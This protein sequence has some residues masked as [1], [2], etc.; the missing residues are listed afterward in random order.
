[1]EKTEA[2]FV[3]PRKSLRVEQMVAKWLHR[4]RESSHRILV[5][6]TSANSNP[7]NFPVK[8]TV[9]I[10]KDL[11]LD[12]YGFDI[13]TYPPIT[14]IS[15]TAGGPSEGK[16]L[17][18]DQILEVN[19]NPME[20]LSSEQIAGVIR[21]SEDQ[22][23]ITILRYSP[24]PK[25]SFLTAEKRARLRSNPVKVHFAEEVVVNGHTQGNSLLFM[26]NVLKVYLENGQTKAFK[27]EKKTT[28]KDIILTLKEKLS[29]HCIEHFALALEEQ[30]HISK[31]YLLH[32][33]EL[34]EK[35]A[36]NRDVRDYRCLF[37]VCFVPKDPLSLLQDD[38]VAF[39]Y[40]YL[41]S[42]SDVIQERF[43]AEMKCS[44]ALRLAALHIQERIITCAQ[45]QKISLKYIEKDWGIENFISPTLLRNMKGKDIK[46]AISFHMK[47]NQSLLEPRQKQLIS[48]AQARLN[49]LKILGDLK[50]YG[51]KIFNATILLQDRESC[52]TLLV[53]AKYGV[54]QVI[55]NKLN[56]MTTLAD[57]GNIS[58]IELSPESEKVS[59]VKI[60]LQDVKPITLLMESYNAKDLACLIAGYCRLF[61]DSSVSFFTWHEKL[62][63]RLSVE[64]GY[65]SRGCSDSEESSEIDSSLELF[66]DLHLLKK[67]PIKTL[68]EEDEGQETTESSAKDKEPFVCDSTDNTSDNSLSA[69]DS[70][71]TESR[72][73]KLS[74]S[75]D[76]L[77]A[78]EDDDLATCSASMPEFFQLYTSDLKET[79]RKDESIFSASTDKG[80]STEGKYTAE[81]DSF[82]SFLELPQL[83]DSLND[84]QTGLSNGRG[85]A[86]QAEGSAANTFSL[87][88]Q[89]YNSGTMQYYSLCSNVTPDGNMES[90]Q[91]RCGS[92][93]G[94]SALLE[95]ESKT[96]DADSPDL[97]N[98]PFLDPPPGFRDSSS[99]D[100]FF[101]AADRLT[102]VD[103]PISMAIS[104]S[105]EGS[106]DLKSPLCAD[107]YKADFS[108]CT[109]FEDLRNNFISRENR[110]ESRMKNE[111]KK[112]ER[113]FRKRRSFVETD[114]TSHVTFP[115]TPSQSL[116]S[117]DHMCCYEREPFLSH[118]Y[119][120]LTVSSLKNIESEPLLLETKPFTYLKPP[121]L[122]LNKNLSPNLMEMEPDTMET[123]S[124]TDSINVTSPISTFRYRSD[125]EGKESSNVKSEEIPCCNERDIVSR[126]SLR[127]CK[128]SANERTNP[129]ETTLQLKDNSFSPHSISALETGEHYLAELP[130]FEQEVKGGLS[131]GTKVHSDRQLWNLFE[132]ETQR[133]DLELSMQ[134]LVVSESN[135][136]FCNTSE[137]EILKPSVQAPSALQNETNFSYTS[138]NECLEP[139]VGTAAHCVIA[140]QSEIMFSNTSEVESM[141]PSVKTLRV[142]QSD[143]KS[144]SSSENVKLK[145]SVHSLNV[146]Q[147]E[148]IFSSTSEIENLGYSVQDFDELESEVV[149]KQSLH[150][151]CAEGTPFTSRAEDEK[152]T[153]VISSLQTENCQCGEE[154]EST[155]FAKQKTFINLEK[156]SL[157]KIKDKFLG[158][159][160]AT[161]LLHMFNETSGVMTRLSIS[162]LKSP[163]Q[164]ELPLSHLVNTHETSEAKKV[165]VLSVSN[166]IRRLCQPD[167]N[168]SKVEA[169]LN[170][171][172]VYDNASLAI[173][174][175]Y[176][177]VEQRDLS[178][179]ES[180]VQLYQDVHHVPSEASASS[181]KGELCETICS[182]HY[183]YREDGLATNSREHGSLLCPSE[184]VCS[185]PA[186]KSDAELPK[187]DDSGRLSDFTRIHKASLPKVGIEPCSCQMAYSNCFRGLYSEADDSTIDS[188][189]TS[190]SSLPLTSPPSSGSVF[191]VASNQ[192]L[193]TGDSSLSIDSKPGESINLN[194]DI[195]NGLK[196]KLY[197]TLG[198]FSL[199]QEDVVALRSAIDQFSESVA[200][201]P[202]EECATHFSENKCALY[203]E[204]R[205]LMSSCQKTIRADQGQEE[206]L[207][208][209]SESFQNLIQLTELCLQFTSCIRCRKRHTDVVGSLKEIVSSYKEFLQAAEKACGKSSSDLSMKLLARQC[210]ALTAGVFCLTQLFRTFT[211]L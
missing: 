132:K 200:K 17:P 182:N 20:D 75:S 57:F 131:G 152:C 184:L 134:S 31:L 177:K 151:A 51:G 42:C 161:E 73:C 211:S 133:E 158:F 27:F 102:P 143:V 168:Q 186:K 139:I 60:Y 142:S 22:M 39:E 46:K 10:Q 82:L 81:P 136:K 118:S 144:C 93:I 165:R 109:I 154:E 67:S 21:A 110:T 175:T 33:D 160:G 30:Y 164:Q 104:S 208:A 5:S 68:E 84:D 54:R 36:D 202:K 47:R 196:N 34:I 190:I 115:L 116:S 52:T 123:K 56:I 114:Y 210:T 92:L 159:S 167:I 100:E 77:D 64:E 201:H 197:G 16:L 26:P 188:E 150:S 119:H 125:P 172:T 94:F 179:S 97:A 105:K 72:G 44:V 155:L 96:G 122:P 120:S 162:T 163:L 83:A 1:M 129:S 174:N 153:E 32:E 49:Y 3:Q 205:R 6:G 113:R 209:V 48:A 135:V 204:S 45:P 74:Y 145:P 207:N 98:I 29:I 66:A 24:G 192:L 53:G 199:L 61:V 171:D 183:F 71:K 11:L 203:G 146:S 156:D 78:L 149:G 4:S 138:K 111:Q 40:L 80:K 65:E 88:C 107:N 13:S 170:L 166:T 85:V 191:S 55:N 87:D 124:L 58:Q 50:T 70:A 86:E 37:R 59:M 194:A 185:E 12:H 69:S 63:H 147:S 106:T 23:S 180:L 157:M 25:S 95:Q 41:Q 108:K 89:L 18:G 181:L 148:I 178:K 103:T 76:S 130:V 28:V 8:L 9:E 101:D 127:I 99:E 126:S 38:P 141:E 2:S 140:S 112:F 189:C 176:H 117:I 35:V 173:Q 19:K 169:H 90:S 121:K 15:V 91:E 7:A 187:N 193:S 195:L 137:N 14:I 128:S 198:G 62:M 79:A 43:A 206:M